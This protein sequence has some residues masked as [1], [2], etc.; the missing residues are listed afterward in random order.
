MWRVVEDIKLDPVVV[1]GAFDTFQK[2]IKNP[3][4]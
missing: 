3:Q 2:Y 4:V 1:T